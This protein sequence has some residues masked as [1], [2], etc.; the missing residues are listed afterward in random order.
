MKMKHKVQSPN[1]KKTHKSMRIFI[2]NVTNR[3]NQ[4]KKEPKYRSIMKSHINIFINI[5]FNLPS[6]SLR[7][8]SVC[9][10]L[11]SIENI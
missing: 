7:R 2:S 9:A 4:Y 11:L 3:K 8:L 1:K 10:C 6:Q 5:F